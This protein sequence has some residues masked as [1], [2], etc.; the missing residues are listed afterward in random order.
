MGAELQQG[1]GGLELS[2]AKRSGVPESN[3]N[4]YINTYRSL[5]F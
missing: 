4:D 2:A 3:Q 1:R 5:I